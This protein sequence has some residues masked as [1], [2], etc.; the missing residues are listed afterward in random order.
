M[1]AAPFDPVSRPCRPLSSRASVRAATRPF[2]CDAAEDLQQRAL[3][4]AVATNDAKNFA[5]L[6]LE[7]HVLKRPEFFD[8][9][10]L[11]NLSA[12]TTS[13]AFRA[14]S[15]PLLQLRVASC[16]PASIA[17]GLVALSIFYGND[18]IEHVALI[19]D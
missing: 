10:A 11:N 18:W 14:R 8:L 12:A 19:S 6:D 4:G 1:Q 2:V 5:L 15:L 9:V 16:F 13:T 3:A 17:V 7:T